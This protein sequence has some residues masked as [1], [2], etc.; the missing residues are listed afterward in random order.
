MIN[1]KEKLVLQ[2]SAGYTLVAVADGGEEIVIRGEKAPIVIANLIDRFAWKKIAK[3]E[4]MERDDFQWLDHAPPEEYKYDYQ[5]DM[6]IYVLL[7][8]EERV[9]SFL[10]KQK[11]PARLIKSL[12]KE[13]RKELLITKKQLQFIQFLLEGLDEFLIDEG[14][15]KS[16]TKREASAL[17]KY[18]Q[19]LKTPTP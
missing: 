9:K 12:S 18:L 1:F 17:I 8:K 15:L 10:D 13:V 5:E 14:E 16:L 11:L 3:I 7:T 2:F 4:T 6:T 19:T